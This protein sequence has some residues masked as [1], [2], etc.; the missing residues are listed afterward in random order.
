MASWKK[1]A[2][3]SVTG[4][5]IIGKTENTQKREAGNSIAAVKNAVRETGGKE[6]NH[7]LQ[8]TLDACAAK[9]VEKLGSVSAISLMKSDEVLSNAKYAEMES[10]VNSKP[11]TEAGKGLMNALSNWDTRPVPATGYKILNSEQ[12]TQL[13]PGMDVDGQI[14]VAINFMYD[15]QGLGTLGSAKGVADVTFTAIQ[16]GE[17]G[18]STY[19]TSYSGVSDDKCDVKTGGFFKGEDMDQLLVQAFDKALDEFCADAAKKI[20]KAKSK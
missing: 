7:S 20:A 19:S 8:P 16:K 10:D 4:N 15:L 13:Y 1:C 3:V 6:L 14:A 12:I 2:V 5:P 9:L 11:K 18:I 17:K